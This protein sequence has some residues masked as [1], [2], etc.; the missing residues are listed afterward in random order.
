MITLIGTEAGIKFDIKAYPWRRAQKLAER[1]KGL[2]WGISKTPERARHF[3]FSEPVFTSRVWMI[4]PTGQTFS[5]QSIQDLLGK[6]IA[7]TGGAQYEGDFEAHRGTLFTVEEGASTLSTRLAMLTQGRV[8][9]VLLG[10]LH[11]TANQF[12]T[13]LNSSHHTNGGP[14][15]VLKQPLLVEP[16]HIAAARNYSINQYLP[17]IDQAIIRLRQRGLV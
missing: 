13:W 3:I 1:G 10:T 6:R 4:V 15:S 5:Y 2:L 11:S 12:E 7:I 17:A 14:W 9:M 8:D 16:A